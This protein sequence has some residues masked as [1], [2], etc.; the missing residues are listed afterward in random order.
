MFINLIEIVFMYDICKSEKYYILKEM[1][2][3]VGN[4]FVKY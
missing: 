4:Y 2:I 3:F 1:S